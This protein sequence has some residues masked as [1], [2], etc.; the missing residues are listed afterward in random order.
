MNKRDRIE[1]SFAERADQVISSVAE[2]VEERA[3]GELGKVIHAL[4]LLLS[5]SP[6]YISKDDSF[7][8]YCGYRAPIGPE[9]HRKNC[10][11]LRAREVM[12]GPA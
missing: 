11:W 7:C 1:R 10:P 6:V 9:Q 12:N 3:T 2:E 5:E 8:V 4:G